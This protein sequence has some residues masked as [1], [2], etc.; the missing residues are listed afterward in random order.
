MT[1]SP[2]QLAT[3][4]QEQQAAEAAALEDQV[5]E[6]A[7]GG[8]GAK[9]AGLVAAALAAWVAAFG[10]LAAA[11]VGAKLISLLA[12]VRGDIDRASRDLGPRS[13]RELERSLER[14][15]MLGA[16]HAAV[17]LTRATG[18]RH[19][20]PEVAVPEDAARAAAALASTVVEQLRLAARMLTPRAVSGSGWRGVIAGIGAA[21]RAV[22]LARQ[23]IAWTLHRAIN[24]GAAQTADHYGAR[25]LW[26]S[27]PDACVICLAYAGQV[28]D[29]DGRFPGGLSMD[30]HS[31]SNTAAA[32]DGPP[33]HPNCLVGSVRVSGPVGVVA[34]D[35]TLGLPLDPPLSSGGLGGDLSHVAATAVAEAIRDFG[36]SNI[37]A[38]TVREYVG[39]LVTIRTASGKELA[40]T[41]NHPVA[42]RSGWVALAELHV[43]D[44]VLSS[45]RPEWEANPIDPDV[46]DVPPRIEEVAESFAVALGTVPLAPED[47]HGDGSGSDVCVVR[48]DGL[49]LNDLDPPIAEGTRKRVLGWGDV[50]AAADLNGLGAVRKFFW[51]ALVAA[52]GSVRRRG[53]AFPF[54]GLCPTHAQ[55]HR[56]AA[57]S[58]FNSGLQEPLAY[59]RSADAEGFC[60]SLLALSGEVTA[61]EIVSVEVGYF[62]GHV[63]NLETSEGWYIGNGIVT[64]NCRCRAVPWMPDWD[65]GPGSFPDLLR[66]QA[67]RSVA[68][69]R[70]RPSES[71]AARR[72]AAQALL[73][74][75]GLSA[76]VRRQA[77]A[78]A[79]GRS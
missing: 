50:S 49:L 66:V 34:V 74:R 59:R 56:I 7:D 13:Q 37:R 27:E 17:F 65:T 73:A 23:T 39:K 6:Q 31:R 1:A 36:R 68:A 75:R 19:A 47:F 58:R 42:T 64:H 53:K 14:A 70:G 76:R 5:V 22:T 26:V 63:Y 55:E 28:S 69:G 8:A 48:A 11:G 44:H 51:A 16:R 38:A 25:L 24:G 72:R 52:T 62:A 30:P 67:W 33:A 29:R 61:D 79:A 60:E 3:L 2:Q 12:K 32:L 71:R 21:R 77:Q 78:T 45:T 18:R 35:E 9:L 40:G 15:T 41:P 43:G 10:A 4:V 54:G 20:A 57:A 46:D